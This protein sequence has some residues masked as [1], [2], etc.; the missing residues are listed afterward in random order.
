MT[1]QTAKPRL[2]GLF[3]VIRHQEVDAGVAAII[4]PNLAPPATFDSTFSL[5]QFGMQGNDQ[6]PNCFWAALAHAM[7]LQ[8][9][10]GLNDRQQPVYVDG[11]TPLTDDAAVTWYRAYQ[12]SKGEPTDVPGS[13]TGVYDGAASIAAQGLA[14]YVGVLGYTTTDAAGNP[15]YDATTIRQAIV[16]F[17]GGAIFCLALDTKAMQEFTDHVPWGTESTNPDAQE[18][19][20]VTGPAYSEN[21]IVFIT[22]AELE[23]STDQFD[24]NCIDGLVLVITK[25][26]VLKNG[27]DAAAALAAKWGLTPV[28]TPAA[29]TADEV[30]PTADELAARGLD[31]PIVSVTTGP[32]E[33]VI[34]EAESKAKGLQKFIFGEAGSEWSQLVAHIEGLKNWAKDREELHKLA[35]SALEGESVNLLIAELGTLV[36]RFGL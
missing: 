14:A 16:D 2:A 7:M 6:L 29:P 24:T 22:W 31:T 21:G 8:A 34:A 15:A 4:P 3:G 20:A 5:S 1:D 26:F 12:A 27:A 36:A 32:V 13:G 35:T 23:M 11:F 28:V 9:L 19:H 30:P 25:G 17:D 18:G 33:R 10:T